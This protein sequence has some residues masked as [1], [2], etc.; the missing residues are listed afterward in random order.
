[1]LVD[2]DAS[3]RDVSAVSWAR[4]DDH[5]NEHRKQL[6]AGAEACWLWACGLMYANRHPERNGVIP[7]EAVALLT[8]LSERRRKRLAAKLVE[9]Q[10]WHRGVAGFEIHDYHAYN[11]TAAQIEQE[12]AAGRERAKRSYQRRMGDSS[13]EDSLKTPPIS[14][15][16]L[17]D[18]SGST[19]LHS[20]VGSK[21][22]TTPLPP[23]GSNER[24]PQPERTGSSGT[25]PGRVPCPGD[26]TL[27]GDQR[28]SLEAS[29]VPGWAIDQIT[30][31]FRAAAVADP[32]D[33]RP[34][35]A[36]RKCLAKAISGRWHNPA[37]R[38][39]RDEAPHPELDSAEDLE[40]ARATQA[41]IEAARAERQRQRDAKIEADIASGALVIPPMPGS[42]QARMA[43]LTLGGPRRAQ[44]APGRG[45]VTVGAIT[46]RG[47]PPKAGPAPSSREHGAISAVGGGI[48]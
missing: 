37:Q 13:P 35:V 8:P 26:L 27:T 4:L 2:K 45:D 3:D 32:D 14:S 28:A 1:M 30:A 39:K 33:R 43:L 18:S 47:D 41:R 36:W 19:P 12:K 7:F 10:L 22:P 24:Q 34:L 5:A 23:I 20:T 42:P 29:L 16:V 48:R 44:V 40:R 11:P 46:G 15:P 9:V 38:P 25:T 31:D 21:D 6:A 17:R